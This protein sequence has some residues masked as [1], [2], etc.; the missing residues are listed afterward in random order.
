MDVVEEFYAICVAVAVC[1]S[2]LWWSSRG[3]TF[4]TIESI[5]CL[6]ADVL[7]TGC[8]TIHR[9][10]RIYISIKSIV[11]EIHY[12]GHA[13][14]KNGSDMNGSEAIF[15]WHACTYARTHT[16]YRKDGVWLATHC[17][18]EKKRNFVKN[19]CVNTAKEMKEHNLSLSLVCRLCKI[20]E[21][22]LLQLLFATIKFIEIN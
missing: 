18:M 17:H 15:E 12:Q 8:W 11:V 5:A 4:W 16:M 10:F 1:S 22:L 2:P 21:I 7:S 9:F 20:F 19:E 3:T 13:K 6:L 14:T